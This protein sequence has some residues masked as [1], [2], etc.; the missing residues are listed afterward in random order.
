MTKNKAL[1]YTK[2]LKQL[3]VE[4]FC[5]IANFEEVLQNSVESN[6]VIRFFN[7]FIEITIRGNEDKYLMICSD[8][9]VLCSENSSGGE[10]FNFNNGMFETACDL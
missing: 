1:R 5:G 8:N 4:D 3:D 2:Y 6:I 10:F 9:T 7:S